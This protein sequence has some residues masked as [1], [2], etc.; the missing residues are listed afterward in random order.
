LQPFLDRAS[1]TLRLFMGKGRSR[2]YGDASFSV[3]GETVPL[4]SEEAIRSRLQAFNEVLNASLEKLKGCA[5]EERLFFTIT[6]LSHAVLSSPLGYAHVGIETYHL[7]PPLCQEAKLELQYHRAAQIEGWNE[8]WGLP[9]PAALATA[10]GSVAVF[11][12]PRDWWDNNSSAALQ[13]LVTIERE[14]LGE[15]AREGWGL[16]EVAAHIHWEELRPYGQSGE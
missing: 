1:G 8:L 5:T 9:R 7:P 14:G 6:L 2:G 3:I 13:A 16:A 12:V 15:A 4:A 11:S 10:A